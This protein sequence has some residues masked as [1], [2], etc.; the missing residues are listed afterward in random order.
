MAGE[1]SHNSD[2]KNKKFKKQVKFKNMKKK[3]ANSTINLLKMQTLV[4]EIP[5]S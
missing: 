2:Q 3:K 5:L 4:A 1:K